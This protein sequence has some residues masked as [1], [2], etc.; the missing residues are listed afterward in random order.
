MMHII[1]CIFL[2]NYFIEG[3]TML[4]FNLPSNYHL[5]KLDYFIECSPIVFPSVSITME[6]KP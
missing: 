4:S 5:M 2:S 6:Q 3:Q 1:R